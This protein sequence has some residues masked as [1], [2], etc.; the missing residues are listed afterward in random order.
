[1]EMERDF[2]FD[3]FNQEREIKENNVKHKAT[4][5]LIASINL[6]EKCFLGFLDN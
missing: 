5:M 2:F 4:A 1:M 6:K 3:F